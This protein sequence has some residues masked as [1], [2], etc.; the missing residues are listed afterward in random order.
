MTSG[1]CI[2]AKIETAFMKPKIYPLGL[3]LLVCFF[4]SCIKWLPENRIV[5][6]WQ[7]AEVQKKRILDNETI[8]TG[9]ESGIF[10]FE[11]N[12]RA[13]YIDGSTRLEGEWFM[14]KGDSGYTDSEGNWHGSDRT[15]FTIKLYDLSSNRVLD[16]Y[17]DRIDFRSSGDKLFAFM[18]GASYTYRYDFRKQ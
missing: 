15:I 14:R 2:C 5:G 12:G 18:E 4:I 16:W 3:F 6:S 10:S 13:I 17:F 7:L 8:S 11:E 1:Y 9:Y